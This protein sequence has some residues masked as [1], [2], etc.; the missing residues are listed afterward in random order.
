[1]SSYWFITLMV[2]DM[3]VVENHYPHR[4]LKGHEQTDWTD[5]RECL[6]STI[7]SEMLI[8]HIVSAPFSLL[9]YAFFFFF[10]FWT[11]LVAG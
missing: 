9:L 7:S 3:C 1:M 10:L 8:L 6:S 11:F 4:S 5:D 2:T